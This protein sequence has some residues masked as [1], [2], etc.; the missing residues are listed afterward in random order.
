MYNNFTV[1]IFYLLSLIFIFDY[2]QEVTEGIYL[3]ENK[4]M[5]EHVGFM[6]N[7]WWILCGFTGLCDCAIRID[8]RMENTQK[9]KRRGSD[10]NRSSYYVV[11]VCLS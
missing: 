5:F 4:L 11:S 8:R 9:E 3:C 1:W 10:G 2:F 7:L 6:L